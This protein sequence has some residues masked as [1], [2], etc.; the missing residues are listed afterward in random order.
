MPGEEK[1]FNGFKQLIDD[2]KKGLKS[3]SD[4]VKLQMHLVQSI[5]ANSKYNEN[6]KLINMGYS[7]IFNKIYEKYITFSVKDITSSIKYSNSVILNKKYYTTDN[8]GVVILTNYNNLLDNLVN[9][10]NKDQSSINIKK[11]DHT[12]NKLKNVL[13]KCD[14]NQKNVSLESFK[15]TKILYN[16]LL[17]I[18]NLAEEYRINKIA[19][20]D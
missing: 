2:Y 9:K 20:E 5:N 14:P 16:G 6:N 1:V 17:K 3:K 13:N 10:Y 18:Y 7:I 4:I 12:L 8:N 19:Q 11:I 15:N